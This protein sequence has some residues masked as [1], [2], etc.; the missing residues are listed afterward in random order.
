MDL[1]IAEPAQLGNLLQ[2]F[3]GSGP[4]NA[5]LREGAV[6]RGLHVSEYGVLDDASAVRHSCASEQEVYALLGL[7]YIE[8]ELARTGAS[9]RPRACPAPARSCRC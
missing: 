1:R 9:C 7:D 8:P 5:A 3:T 6:A 4:H 2:H